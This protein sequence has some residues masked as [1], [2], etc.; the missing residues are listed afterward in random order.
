MAIIRLTKQ[1]VVET[2][3]PENGVEAQERRSLFDFIGE[4][5]AVLWK[6]W[7]KD[8]H[9]ASMAEKHFVLRGECP[10][11]RH[12][13]A[14]PSITSVYAEY[15]GRPGSGRWIAGCR[16]EACNGYILGI[17]KQVPEAGHGNSFVAVY[18]TH[19]PVG[20]P[21]DSLPEEIPL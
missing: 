2:I 12:L 19:Y 20:K 16:C 15:R 18:D 21:D 1:T 13:A 10:H 6:D 3:R 4:S 17:V 11:C 5:L 9:L 14:F 8:M 7:S